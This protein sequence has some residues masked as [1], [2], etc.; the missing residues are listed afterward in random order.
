VE[1]KEGRGIRLEKEEKKKKII[2]VCVR[3]GKRKKKW[4]GRYEF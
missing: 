4:K 1:S 2:E 3:E